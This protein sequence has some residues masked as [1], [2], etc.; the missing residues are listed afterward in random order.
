M[1]TV[2]VTC[3]LLSPAIPASLLIKQNQANFESAM[4]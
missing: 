2:A 3:S 1:A 4:K